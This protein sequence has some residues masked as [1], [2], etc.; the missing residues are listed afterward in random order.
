HVQ[1]LD[2]L[3]IVIEHALSAGDM[4]DRLECWS[5]DFSN[6]LR[7]WIS[8]REKLLSVLVEE[9]MVIAEVRTTHGQGKIFVFQL[10]K[11]CL[12][13]FFVF[14]DSLFPGRGFSRPWLGRHGSALYRCA[15]VRR[16]PPRGSA[17]ISRSSDARRSMH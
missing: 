10:N 12:F 11:F 7:D 3:C 13:F 8:H 5:A 1:G 15:S 14:K 16:L 17:N 6:S 9:Q 4:P 2:V